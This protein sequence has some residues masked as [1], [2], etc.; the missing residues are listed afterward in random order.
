[1]GLSCTQWVQ[2]CWRPSAATAPAV[3]AVA[4]ATVPAVAAAIAA[5]PAAATLQIEPGYCCWLWLQKSEL[6]CLR[7]R[8]VMI[9]TE[10][11]HEQYVTG[12]IIRL[13]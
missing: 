2:L 1:M 5:D 3:A 7:C 8:K 11:A 9:V 4:A 6:E 13:L 12:G 10:I